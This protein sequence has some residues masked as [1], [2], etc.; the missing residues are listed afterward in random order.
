MKQMNVYATIIMK[1]T[2]VYDS[3]NG[4]VKYLN[5]TTTD[6]KLTD[7]VKHDDYDILRIMK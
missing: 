7:L 4:S 3:R 1:K 6:Y 2:Y 5:C